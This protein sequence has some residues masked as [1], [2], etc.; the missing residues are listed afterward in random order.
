MPQFTDARGVPI[1]YDVHTAEG[2]PRG[3]VQLAHGYGEH[4][5]RYGRLIDL[6]IDPFRQVGS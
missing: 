1:F 5:G 2:S 4:A 6:A 3:V